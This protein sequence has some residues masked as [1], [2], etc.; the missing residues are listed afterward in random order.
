MLLNQNKIL[1]YPVIS[2]LQVLIVLQVY[3]L[4]SFAGVTLAE[5]TVQNSQ[6][7]MIFSEIP[8]I[9]E[10]PAAK[11]TL[12]LEESLNIA[13][14]NNSLFNIQKKDTSIY[15][16]RATR[17]ALGFLPSLRTSMSYTYQTEK[18]E[19]GEDYKFNVP[20]IGPLTFAGFQVEDRWKRQN[21]VTV[22]QPL[23]NLYEIYHN[24]KITI[25]NREKAL[26]EEEY[27][28]NILALSVYNKYFDILTTKY[29]IEAI[30]KDIEEVELLLELA[31]ARY[32]NG[33]A[34]LRDVQ[35][36]EVELDNA[37]YSLV[38]KENKLAEALN[39][40]KKLLG[41]SL[42]DV[43][44]IDTRFD[45]F[46]ELEPLDGLQKLAIEN[47]QKIK[48]QEINIKLAKHSKKLSY[49]SYIPDVNFNLNYLNQSGDDFMPKNN[50]IMGFN[51]DF[52]FF[53][54]GKREIK[55]KEKQL[56]VEQS[57]LMLKD[58]IQDVKIA[59]QKKYNRI[60][61]TRK[62]IEK[63]FKAVDLAKTNFDITSTRY[64]VGYAL[65]T[66]VLSDQADLATARSDY[67]KALFKEQTAIA[68]LKQV[69]GE[70][71]DY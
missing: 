71:I 57:E 70:L 40:F 45:S 39:S 24:Y 52:E 8:F 32:V 60:I 36:V 18:A 43:L 68:E 69:L 28:G 27:A 2:F 66:D 11:Y 5:T 23:T 30:K 54:W 35:K 16:L 25:L 51:M 67:Y 62:L 7:D 48:Q 61:E 58:Y 37:R 29:Q 50:L 46:S 49:G 17:G 47:N 14:E 41:L 22:S 55:I 56:Q 3:V 63:S 53:D 4:S 64:N 19:I 34:L 10:T 31:E 65:L 21:T 59:V 42:D 38:L 26:I 44:V 6:S 13:L 33:T 9:K 20:G 15:K 12:N 1:K